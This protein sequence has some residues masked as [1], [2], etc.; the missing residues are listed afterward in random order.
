M[1][2]NF[3]NIILYKNFIATSKGSVD[4]FLDYAENVIK[5]HARKVQGYSIIQSF[6]QHEFDVNNEKHIEYVNDLGRKL[7]YTLYANSPTLV[8]IHADSMGKC[9]H[10]H[11]IT[12]NHDLDTNKAIYLNRRVKDVR[13]ANDELM[14]QF[15]LEV[16]QP[17]AFPKTQR[18]YWSNKRNHWLDDLKD[19]I[20]KVLFVATSIQEFH[21]NLLAEG[22]TP[23][24]YKKNGGL[25]E[26]FSYKVTDTD[27]N[28]HTKRSDKL[29][30]QYT[31]E[32]IERRLLDNKKKKD[33]DSIMPMDEWIK[34]QTIKTVATPPKQEVSII[35]TV[36][37]VEIQPPL[38]YKKVEITDIMEKE[39]QEEQEMQEKNILEEL[40]NDRVYQ[41]LLAERLTILKNIELIKEKR[42]KGIV[43][44]GGHFFHSEEKFSQ[45][46]VPFV[47]STVGAKPDDMN[48][49]KYS[50]IAVDDKIASKK[51][52]SYLIDLGHKEIG[53]VG[54]WDISLIDYQRYLGYLKA[55]KEANLTVNDEHLYFSFDNHYPYN[56]E[57]QP[58]SRK[59]E[60][61]DHNEKN[62]PPHQKSALPDAGAGHGAGHVP[63]PPCQRR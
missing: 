24:L 23:V 14:S 26:R 6:P 11:I 19:C 53:F 59:Y 32:A 33:L 45:I 41:E 17:S 12:L 54:A 5:S 47:F 2:H 8:V 44:L 31:R 7:A 49:A 42:L 43:F 10:N 1:R 61:K 18:E 36:E 27:N 39:K 37:R 63:G 34:Q 48:K 57:E 20:D 25:K 38:Q 55:M 30:E 15:H 9:L 16:C 60:R 35:Q 3:P 40:V 56:I 52:V 21:D 46:S 29:G 28:I 50:N 22:I 51:M 62:P 4:F 58:L 13:K